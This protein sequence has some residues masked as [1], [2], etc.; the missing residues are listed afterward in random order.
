VCGTDGA[1]V[2]KEV[3]KGEAGGCGAKRSAALKWLVLCPL[4][5]EEE[6]CDRDVGG[7]ILGV[8]VWEN[9]AIAAW[10]PPPPPP[11]PALGVVLDDPKALSGFANIALASPNPIPILPLL[12]D[13][14]CAPEPCIIDDVTD[15]APP[16]PGAL[17]GRSKGPE[18]GRVTVATLVDPR[19]SVP[20]KG[21]EAFIG[22]GEAGGKGV[23]E[24]ETVVLTVWEV[25]GGK[26]DEEGRVSNG[27]DPDIIRAFPWKGTGEGADGAGV[28]DGSGSRKRWEEVVEEVVGTE[29]ENG[30]ALGLVVGKGWD[31][32]LGVVE[33]KGWV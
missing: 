29:E 4:K 26:L 19:P 30:L 18:V 22:D 10:P 7:E 6:V 1:W 24:D 13:R 16:T 5:G 17:G 25:V 21:R 15:D 28:E 14:V 3:E 2:E 8:F 11:A 27:E 9:K 31:E 20:E 33:E 12:T 23:N 32:V